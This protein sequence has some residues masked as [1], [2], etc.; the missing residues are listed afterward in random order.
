MSKADSIIIQ[1]WHVKKWVQSSSLY[2]D[3]WSEITSLIRTLTLPSTTPHFS[4]A[5]ILCHERELDRS[6]R[7][8]V[9]Y[10]KKLGHWEAVKR[11]N[12][13]ALIK[14]RFDTR[15]GGLTALKLIS[16]GQEHRNAISTHTWKTLNKFC[17]AVF[18]LFAPA[19]G[20][21]S[22]GPIGSVHEGGS[23]RWR[24]SLGVSRAFVHCVCAC[25][26]HTHSTTTGRIETDCLIVSATKNYVHLLHKHKPAEWIV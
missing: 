8:C 14:S 3:E 17:R 6:I 4:T 15:G 5:I 13:N 18:C 9:L 25:V 22:T 23:R 2:H 26:C 21:R 1:K 12:K 16:R 10:L 19:F 24:C 11:R 20:L 7:S